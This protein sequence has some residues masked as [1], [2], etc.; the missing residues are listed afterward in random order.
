MMD[1]SK[2]YQVAL[3][4]LKERQAHLQEGLAVA[5]FAGDEQEAADYQR[6]LDEVDMAIAYTEKQR[7]QECEL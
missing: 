2:A 6:W 3:D 5:Q 7:R 1:T 4:A